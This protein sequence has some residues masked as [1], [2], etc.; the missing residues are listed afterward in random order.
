MY[1]AS[2]A[3]Q[4]WKTELSE[5]P[6]PPL[7]LWASVGLCGASVG[8]LWALCGLCEPLWA[9]VGPLW[10]LCGPLWTLCEHLWASVGPLWDALWGHEEP[11][12]ARGENI[13]NYSVFCMVYGLELLRESQKHCNVRYWRA[14]R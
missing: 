11:L 2:A 6:S 9:S 10:A 13:V 5:A 7:R 3:V 1:R 8:P 14:L 4:T 12:W